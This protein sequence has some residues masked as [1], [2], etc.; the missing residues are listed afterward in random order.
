MKRIFALLLFT[1]F[2]GISAKAQPY[3]TSAGL[4]L[5]FPYGFT[6]RHF[7]DR[8]NSLE[9]I[10]AG[11]M[12]GFMF[13]GFIENENRTLIYPGVNWYWGPGIHGGFVDVR[14]YPDIYAREDYAGPVMGIDAVL[15]VE[16]TFRDI[17]LN[18]SF[19]LMPSLNLAGYTGWNG[20]NSAISVRY[21]LF[22]R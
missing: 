22:S 2:I 12:R 5:G 4:R 10:A 1:V 9:L 16:Y 14:R 18:L 3:R 15:G 6:V 7:I 13:A 19:D 20:L 8:K 11:N 17:P 21:V